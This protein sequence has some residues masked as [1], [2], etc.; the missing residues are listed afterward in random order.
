MTSTLT[1]TRPDAA[2]AA[3]RSGV[4][5]LAAVG[6]RW[7]W[8]Y[9]WPLAVWLLA[10]GAARLWLATS[11]RTIDGAPLTNSML[12]G[13]TTLFSTPIAVALLWLWGSRFALGLGHS[14][15]IVFVVTA[16]T[17]L[18]LPIVVTLAG[19]VAAVNEYRYVG[20]SGLRVFIQEESNTLGADSGVVNI[21]TVI[22]AIY[23]LPLLVILSVMLAG[24]IGR[25]IAGVLIGLAGGL[26][27]YAAGIALWGPIER[28][29]EAL[30][31]IT[32]QW[33][34]APEGVLSMGLACV[35][36]LTLGWF[37]FRGTRA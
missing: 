35:G 17:S 23:V 26:L 29:T 2:R 6:G 18:V 12:P 21:A 33:S 27:A 25:G 1:P 7:L 24:W 16:A 37:L 14:R 8:R 11:P 32:Q 5:V 3:F 19:A 28:L 31:P 13:A 22:F 4:G 9:W 36:M 30:I 34:N 20:R 10:A 15:G